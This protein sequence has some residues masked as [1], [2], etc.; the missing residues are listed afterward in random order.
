LKVGEAE[1]DK[2]DGEVVAMKMEKVADSSAPPDSG[3]GVDSF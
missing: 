3:M 1:D 2:T